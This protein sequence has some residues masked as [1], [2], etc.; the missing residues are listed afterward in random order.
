MTSTTHTIL[1]ALLAVG[2]AMPAFAQEGVRQPRP[3][4][5]ERRGPEVTER[6][7]KTLRLGRGGSF[8]LSNIAGDVIITGGGGNDVRI[9]AVKRLR[10]RS[11]GDPGSGLQ[12]I[13]IEVLELSNRVEVRTLYPTLQRR[14]ALGAVDYTVTLPQ[15][16]NVTVRSVAGDVRVTNVSGELRAESV[17]GDVTASDTR[18]VSS[19]K[20]VGGNV[21]LTNGASETSLNIGTVSGDLTIKG[22]QARALDAASVSGT[23]RLDSIASERVAVKTV[24]G[25]VEYGGELAHHGRYEFVSHSGNVLLN[26]AGNTGFD[27]AASTFSGDV[28]SDYAITV[29]GN[30]VNGTARENGRGRRGRLGGVRTLRGSFGDGSASL[31]LQSF[32]GNVAITRR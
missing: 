28:R 13:Q 2:S 10:V 14:N 15:D 19:L 9:D 3:Q 27:V 18:R 21:L 11:A 4:A 22:L 29:R 24:S 5:E 31:E 12:D 23:V 6:F 26:L 32:S 7:S 1:V 16:A 8:D 30:D 20:S 17:R 25:D